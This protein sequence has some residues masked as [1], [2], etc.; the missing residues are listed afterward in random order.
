MAAR[1]YGKDI[2][3]SYVNKSLGNMMLYIFFYLVLLGFTSISLV[4]AEWSQTNGPEGGIVYRQIVAGQNCLLASLG[5]SSFIT[6]DNGEHWRILIKNNSSSLYI[7]AKSI[8]S[9]D[10]FA[11][12]TC[13]GL[14][15]S[16]NNGKDWTQVNSSWTNTEFNPHID[17]ITTVF[18]ADSLLIV[19][20]NN[21]DYMISR[22]GGIKWDSLQNGLN[23]GPFIKTSDSIFAGMG[24]G[25]VYLSVNKGFT[26]VPSNIGFPQGA[27]VISL[28]NIGGT[29][30][31]C[32]GWHGVYKSNDHGKTWNSI[33]EGLPEQADF[34]A[35]LATD[36][37]MFIGTDTNGIY[38]NSFLKPG[39]WESAN[40]GIPFKTSINGLQKSG[41]SIFVGTDVGIYRLDD[42]GKSWVSKNSGIRKSW[43]NRI[44][45]ANQT[46]Y[47]SY[48]QDISFSSADDGNIWVPIKLGPENSPIRYVLKTQGMLLA[49]SK[50]AYFI[51]KD[52]GK[53]WTSPNMVFLEEKV[54]SFAQR[55]KDFFAGTYGKG[56]FN[57]NDSL[58]KW[59]PFNSGLPEKMLYMENLVLVKNGIFSTTYDEGPFF[60]ENGGQSWLLKNRGLPKNPVITKLSLLDTVLIAAVWMHGIFISYDNGNSWEKKN[61]GL[62][63][64]ISIKSFAYND[65]TIVIAAL[66]D[67]IYFSTY[68]CNGWK[69]LLTPIELGEILSVA[70][71]SRFLFV[72]TQYNGVWKYPI[73]EIR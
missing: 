17:A 47:A 37:F 5:N 9:N 55:G 60:L 8:T 30:L 15:K 6:S 1:F 64:E 24:G 12:D 67:V 14:F 23:F 54:I 10:F 27:Y 66:H 28:F 59:V 62:P 11:N 68:Q 70:F 38:R 42:N 45:V 57:F 65:N 4:F 32:T 20:I 16:S 46:L 61:A 48:G 2:I 21:D 35:F 63:N 34:D 69:K 39:K 44:E 7:R 72:G 51:S 36:N 26:W 58:K 33:N 56:V 50:D 73:S 53:S 29:F 71:T 31:A 40:I 43:I 25:G 19:G 18:A 52:T 13:G 49:C 3:Y 22:N 41:K